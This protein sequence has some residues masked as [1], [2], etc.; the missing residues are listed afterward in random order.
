MTAA[1][2]T[3]LRASDE[4]TPQFVIFS[5]V[6]NAFDEFADRSYGISTTAVY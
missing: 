1:G 6:A 4:A 3:I 2:G 5:T